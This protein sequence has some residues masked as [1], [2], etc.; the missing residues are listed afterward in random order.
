MCVGVD[1]DVDVCM[2]VGMCMHLCLCACERGHVDVGVFA[3]VCA[4]MVCMS[5]SVCT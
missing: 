3:R 2:C 1:V 4:G 5:V